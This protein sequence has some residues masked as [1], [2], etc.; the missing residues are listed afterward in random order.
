MQVKLLNKF[1]SVRASSQIGG[2]KVLTDLVEEL[3]E[4][5]IVVLFLILMFI[6]LCLGNSLIYNFIYICLHQLTEIF[7]EFFC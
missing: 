5:A 6:N 1:A 7:D 4:P 2:S 3:H